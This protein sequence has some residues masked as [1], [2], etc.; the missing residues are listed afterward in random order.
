MQHVVNKQQPVAID[1]SITTCV[2]PSRAAILSSSPPSSSLPT[3]RQL[4]GACAH[5][6]SPHP[7]LQ[8]R[9]SSSDFSPC[10]SCPTS[11]QS[12]THRETSD[13]HL[14]SPSSTS[15]SVSTQA[16]SSAAALADST[17]ASPSLGGCRPRACT[18]NAT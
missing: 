3:H 2:P 8:H 9:D 12:L 4:S 18:W 17:A 16:C 15:M 5:H 13:T 6:L 7:P 11:R 14:P 1:R 10:M